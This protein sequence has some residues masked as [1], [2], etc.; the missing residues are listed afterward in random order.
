MARRATTPTSDGI[1]IKFAK[2]AIGHPDG[3]LRRGGRGGADLRL[4][5]RPDQ[6]DRRRLV[7]P[8]LHAAARA[9]QLVEDQPREGGG[10]DRARRD[11]ARRAGRGRAREGRRPLGAPPTTRRATATVPDDLRAALDADPAAA[12]E[13]FEGLDANNRYAILHR[14]QD[15]KR[16]ETRARRIAQ[17]VAMLAR[18]ET[19]HP[20]RARGSGASSRGRRT[21]PS[22]TSG[23]SRC[24]CASTNSQ[25]QLAHCLHPREPVRAQ[26]VDRGDRDRPQRAVGVAA[27]STPTRRP[28]SCRRATASAWNVE[29][30]PS[31]P[32]PGREHV[33]DRGAQLARAVEVPPLRPRAGGQR[34]GPA[35]PGDEVVVAAQ[36]VLVRGPSVV[37]AKSSARSLPQQRDVLDRA[38]YHQ[39]RVY[40]QRRSVTTI[41]MIHG[42]ARP[43]AC[44]ASPSSSSCS[45]SRSSRSRCP[46]S[47]ATS[48][49]RRPGCSG[50][51]APTR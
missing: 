37:L 31:R 41:S 14:L 12:S 2:K 16:P 21:R 39:S 3:G 32:R 10:A 34:A 4:D 46:R 5:R 42:N 1:W 29:H 50:C 18:G 17:F 47:G 25:P 23:V 35:R 6:A 20:R 27:A 11:A 28:R 26:Q 8:A 19:L 51:S 9:Q 40:R 36:V 38:R 43:R 30:A 49:S 44:S 48:A 33:V 45:T 13:L 24:G 7:P 22:S 15:A